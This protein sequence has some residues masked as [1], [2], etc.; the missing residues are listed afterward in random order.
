M[1][2]LGVRLSMLGLFFMFSHK[3]GGVKEVANSI[4][5]DASEVSDT[6]S[7]T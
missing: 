1:S 7:F 4:R 2:D 3:A 6:Q 5:S